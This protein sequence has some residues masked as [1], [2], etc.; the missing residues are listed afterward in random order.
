MKIQIETPAG[1]YTTPEGQVRKLEHEC[2]PIHVIDQLFENIFV[3]GLGAVLAHLRYTA[4]DY[5][6]EESRHIL[7]MKCEL[8]AAALM[9][10]RLK[11]EKL[12]GLLP[13]AMGASHLS[14]VAR[15]IAAALAELY[16]A[17]SDIEIDR[18]HVNCLPYGDLLSTH[19]DG[20]SGA[21][22]TGLYFANPQWQ[23]DWHGELIICDAGGESRYAIQPKPGRVVLFPG[24]IPHRAGAPSRACYAHRLT[25]SHKFRAARRDSGDAGGKPE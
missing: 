15:I 10:A 23:T 12:L 16:P 2:G 19:Q 21:A 11:D 22:L 13:K 18:I 17:Y 25:V 24:E 8:P 20:P 7:H 3:E 4:S 1:I 9:A 5:D 6:T 14:G